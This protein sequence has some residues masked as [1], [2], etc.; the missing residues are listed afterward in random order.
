MH[1]LR[2]RH[3]VCG[4]SREQQQ[5]QQEGQSKVLFVAKQAACWVDT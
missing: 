4:G 1:G 2:Q 3:C 5:Q